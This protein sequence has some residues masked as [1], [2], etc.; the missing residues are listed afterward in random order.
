MLTAL[1]SGDTTSRARLIELIYDQLHGLACGLMR[2]ERV[3]HT[4]QATALLH[5]AYVR[6]I[7]TAPTDWKSRAHFFGAAAEV[8]RRILIDHARERKALKRGGDRGREPLDP[9]IAKAF[10]S[11]DDLLDVDQALSKLE[12]IEP[13]KASIV[14]MRFFAGLTLD[15]IAAVLDVSVITVKRD[16]RFARAWMVN[17]LEEHSS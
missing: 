16:W 17:Q 2:G 1:S 8:M 13:R 10:Q 6:L 7:G 15:E 14:K 4:L 9:M 11:P 5:E 12:T 3:D